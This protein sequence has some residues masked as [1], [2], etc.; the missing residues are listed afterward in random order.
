[1]Y[2]LG[3]K[4]GLRL[5]LWSVDRTKVKGVRRVFSKGRK[6]RNKADGVTNE[7]EEDGNNDF[8]KTL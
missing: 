1:M 4:K 6:E 8:E 5:K 7:G 3:Q 2:Y